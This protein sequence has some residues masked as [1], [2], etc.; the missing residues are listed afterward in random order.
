M[1]SANANILR[2]SASDALDQVQRAAAPAIKEG[3]RQAGAMLDQGGELVD[4]VSTRASDI[5]VDSGKS[6]IAFTK[7][8]PF[9][10]LLLAVGAG[11]LLISA[12]K[13]IQSRR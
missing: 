5:A 8:N 13:S 2:D 9:T 6:M 10:A 1:T 7:K 4:S 11:A 3:K 12:T